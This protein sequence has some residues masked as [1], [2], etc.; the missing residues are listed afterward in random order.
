MFFGAMWPSTVGVRVQGDQVKKDDEESSA[1]EESSATV[2]H[3]EFLESAKSGSLQKINKILFRPD[4][5]VNY[6]ATALY[7][8]A[9][10]LYQ[11]CDKGHLNVVERLLRHK[12]SSCTT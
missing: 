12:V 9:T 5:N 7:S 6:V 10:A 3:D 8:G 2:N 1:A 11:A 4:L